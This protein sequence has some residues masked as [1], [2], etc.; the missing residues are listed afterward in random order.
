VLELKAEKR[1]NLSGYMKEAQV[2]SENFAKARRR[3][4]DRP[5]AVAAV[6]A[7]NKGIDKTY[8]ILELAEFQRLMRRLGK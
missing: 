8:V 3:G 7:R 5:V 6:K 1:I 2:E 4:S